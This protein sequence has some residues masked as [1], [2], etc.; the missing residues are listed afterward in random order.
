MTRAGYWHGVQCAQDR[1]GPVPS[2][3]HGG[4]GRSEAQPEPGHSSGGPARFAKLA[5]GDSACRTVT[6]S[7]GKSSLARE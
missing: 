2:P 6:D 5:A 4:P 3:G 7:R 1:P